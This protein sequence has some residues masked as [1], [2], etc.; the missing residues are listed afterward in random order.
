MSVVT[1]SLLC[2]GITAVISFFVVA[3]MIQINRFMSRG[4][5]DRED[6]AE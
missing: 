6:A 3:L 1:Y 4:A 2:Y 5:D